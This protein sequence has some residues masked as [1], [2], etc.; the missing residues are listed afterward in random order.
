MK[1]GVS[2][3]RAYLEQK[4]AVTKNSENVMQQ[5]LLERNRKYGRNNFNQG[6]ERD[7]LNK[8]ALIKGR[9]SAEYLHASIAYKLKLGGKGR[10]EAKAEIEKLCSIAPASYECMQSQALFSVTDPKMR[11]KLQPFYMH[12]T[13]H[14]FEKAVA[15]ID[16]IFQDE[17]YEHNLRLAY[18][19][20]MG[21]VEGREKEAVKGL[22]KMLFEIPGESSLKTSISE[23]IREYSA[24][25]LANSAL[26]KLK[27]KNLSKA[28][29]AD[30]KKAIDTDPTN[31]DASYWR[32]MLAIREYY[33][34]LDEA[35][36]FYDKKQYQKAEELYS[37]ALSKDSKS[38]YAY[39]G[40]A[41]IYSQR[42]NEAQFK[43]YSALALTHAKNESYSEQKRIGELV[44]SLKGD[45]IINKAKD[46]LLKGEKEEAFVLYYDALKLKSNDPWIYHEIASVHL[47][48]HED[49]KAL[50][51]YMLAPISLH[52]N[53][54]YALAYALTL[55]SLNRNDEALRVMAPYLGKNASIDSNYQ[56]IKDSVEI[57]KARDLYKK[58]N[59]SEALSILENTK[60]SD[61]DTFKADIYFE[62]GNYARAEE[63][64]KRNLQRDP[65]K[66]YDRVMLA[67]TY[68]SMGEN[69]KAE[70]QT[71]Y[72]VT[73]LGRL[74]LEDIRNLGQLFYDLGDPKKAV[75]TWSYV[76]DDTDG[77]HYTIVPS[78][79][80][81]N[82]DGSKSAY[83]LVNEK[84]P[85]NSWTI[86]EQYYIKKGSMEK[87]Y[88]KSMD[89]KLDDAKYSER[90]TTPSSK[91]VARANQK[92]AFQVGSGSIYA[93]NKD[94]A[95][96]VVHSYRLD[97]TTS[98]K[99]VRVA[100]K[101]QEDAKRGIS[102]DLKNDDDRF[103]YAFI[104]RNIAKTEEELHEDPKI[105]SDI[106]R[107]AYGVLNKKE[108]MYKD[109]ALYTA[110]LRTPDTEENWL[111]RS[112]RTGGSES[113]L[114]NNLIIEDGIS[115]LRDSGHPGY[116]DN[117]GCTNVFNLSMPMFGGRV[118]FQSDHTS[119]DAGRLQGGSWNDMFGTI[120]SEGTTDHSKHKR[121]FNSYA[122][123]YDGY[124]LHFD[125]GTAP[126]I[127]NHRASD[128]GIVGGLS[129]TMKFSDL[130]LTPEFYHRSK[131]NS[132]VTFFGDRDPKTGLMFGAVK[133]TGIRLSG[134]LSRTISDGYWFS[135]GAEKLK[136]TN[137]EDNHDVVAMGGYYRHIIDRPNERLTFSPSLMYMHYQRDLSGY[138][139][140]QGGY[141]SPQS[142]LSAAATL[143]YMLR[144]EHTSVMIEASASVTHSKTRSQAR[145]PI[146]SILPVSSENGT[147]VTIPDS[148]SV[149]ADDS[150]VTFGG[151]VRAAVE[152]RLSSHLVVGAA[153]EAS[154]SEDYSPVNGMIYFRY[155]FDSYNGDLNMPPKAPTPYVNW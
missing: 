133:K 88:E 140:G 81:D 123:A 95:A 32:E 60:S 29:V 24:H 12:V 37:K 155:Y 5:K 63:L 83:V 26:P 64:L 134:S 53:S 78:K 55:N 153:F 50:D 99:K 4:T 80:E 18:Y 44:R 36:S 97:S 61:A 46:S 106:Y 51:V 58:G 19:S 2:D 31:P 75:A 30:I 141:Y 94:A 52:K 6:I 144:Y 7:A 109:D 115:F 138:T 76:L 11:V 102:I 3:S 142:Y 120:F 87:I 77:R 143:R 122:I 33:N 34:L 128:S 21:Y 1:E 22:R 86:K 108:D 154:K 15:D 9:A 137:V 69:S 90:A 149:S 127:S 47:D 65:D 85:D 116:S 126:K 39:V 129:Y 111:V 117:K 84:Y 118:A 27:N 132:V 41:R 139:L 103:T 23:K 151:G 82:D 152:Q 135:F 136:G 20:A 101:V 79:I 124:N 72:L 10:E 62:M 45:I 96:W 38:P 40:L 73:G 35:D 49:D 145:Y 16:N 93:D 42:G 110:D 125:I 130:T 68:Y 107:K 89:K 28:A 74:S 71:E 91:T 56:R 13:N 59:V 67:K 17:P 112:V 150:S 54:E 25:G 104:L 146:K 98:E 147:Y 114:K 57:E 113:Y 121:S 119:L 48:N 66:T 70:Q 43:K 148:D 14:D 92:I 131:D 8:L 105:V 100:R